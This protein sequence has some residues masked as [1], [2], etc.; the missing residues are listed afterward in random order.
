MNDLPIVHESDGYTYSNINIFTKVR[1]N[2]IEG[3]QISL[4]RHRKDFEQELRVNFQ[5][6]RA[7]SL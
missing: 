4:V 5:F 1:E 2:I 3:I 6:T 7:H